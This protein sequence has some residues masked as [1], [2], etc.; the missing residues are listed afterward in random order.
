MLRERKDN[1]NIFIRYII[2]NNKRNIS[3]NIHLI[4]VY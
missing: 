3:E 1:K 4:D 2:C